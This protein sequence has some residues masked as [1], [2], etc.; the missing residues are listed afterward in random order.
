MAKFRELLLHEQRFIYAYE[1]E[2]TPLTC[3]TDAPIGSTL[4][5]CQTSCGSIKHDG[6]Y[7]ARAP[8]RFLQADQPTCQPTEHPTDASSEST[9]DS[10]M[11]LHR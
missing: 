4:A 7:E 6:C 3:P 10:E 11:A 1:G 5:N 8:R 9:T 2:W